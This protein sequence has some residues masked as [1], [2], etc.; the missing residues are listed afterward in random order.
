[1]ILEKAFEIYKGI[2]MASTMGVVLTTPFVAYLNG[3][4]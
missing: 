2:V 4:I 3:W 1:M